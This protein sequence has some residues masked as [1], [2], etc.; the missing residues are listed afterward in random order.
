[1]PSIERPRPIVIVNAQ[2]RNQFGALGSVHLQIAGCEA[3]ELTPS[4]ARKLS[5]YLDAGANEAEAERPP[6]RGRQVRVES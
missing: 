4:E 3:V 2:P 6:D 5:S 1:M